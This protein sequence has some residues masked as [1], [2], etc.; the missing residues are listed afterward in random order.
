MASMDG[1]EAVTPGGPESGSPEDA[2][3]PVHDTEADRRR[4]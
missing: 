3:S 1:G 4:L 2:P